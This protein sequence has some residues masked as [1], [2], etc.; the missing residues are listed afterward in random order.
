[1][2]KLVEPVSKERGR[3]LEGRYGGK[4]RFLVDESAGPALADEIRRRG[5]NATYIGE[6]GLKGHPDETIFSCAWQEDRVLLTHDQDFLD[7]RRFPPHR[8]PGLV[9]LPGA[10]GMTQGLANALDTI[11]AFVGRHRKF[12]LGAKITITEDGTWTEKGFRKE[13]GRHYELRFKVGPHGNVL[14]WENNQE[15]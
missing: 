1:M 6:L 3:D 15:S 10:S 12:Y 11:L 14:T 5:W 8:N 9:I 13:Q 4:A 2:W 7:D